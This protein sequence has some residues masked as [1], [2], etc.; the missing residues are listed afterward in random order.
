MNRIWLMLSFPRFE[1]DPE[2]TAW[3]QALGLLS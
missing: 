3:A 1:G 2:R